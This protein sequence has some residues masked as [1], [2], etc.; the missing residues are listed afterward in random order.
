M[1]WPLDRKLAPPLPGIKECLP[2]ARVLTTWHTALWRVGDHQPSGEYLGD[3]NVWRLMW[4]NRAI[5]S[6]MWP[7]AKCLLSWPATSCDLEIHNCECP[8][9]DRYRKEDCILAL[10]NAKVLRT[11]MPRVVDTQADETV[12]V[13]VLVQGDNIRVEG[14]DRDAE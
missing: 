9:R 6:G 8:P 1:K 10:P 2:P 4:P 12:I 7:W 11:W 5:L 13:W 3:V 14:L